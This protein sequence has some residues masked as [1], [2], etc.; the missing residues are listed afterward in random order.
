M[1][2]SIDL[3]MVSSFNDYGVIMLIHH[4]NYGYHYYGNGQKMTKMYITS[5]NCWK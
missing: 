3:Q 4:T 5:I 1:V 2:V